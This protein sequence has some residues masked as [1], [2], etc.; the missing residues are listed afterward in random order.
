MKKGFTLIELLVVIGIIALLSTLAT[1]A[2]RYSMTKARLT[3]AQ[4]EIGEIHKAIKALELDSRLWPGHQTP[5][6]IH[7]AEN[8]EICG[9]DLSGDTCAAS[10]S[11]NSSGIVGHDAGFPNWGGHY[12]KKLPLDPWQHEYFFDTDYR[13]NALKEPC[14]CGGICSDAVVIGSYGPDGEGRPDGAGAYGCD[15]IILIIQE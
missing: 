3:K 12:M 1:F 13:I 7:S 4:A 9:P 11:S 2:V 14:G 15:D 6:A 10:L 5:N 8:N